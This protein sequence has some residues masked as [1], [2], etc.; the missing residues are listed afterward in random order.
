MTLNDLIDA[1]TKLREENPKLGSAVVYKITESGEL[2][3]P[4][5][6]VGFFER[7]T[8]EQMAEDPMSYDNEILDS[9]GEDGAQVDRVVTVA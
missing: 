1:L 7:M 6:G 5:S 3:D 4:L 2:G 8:V 9:L